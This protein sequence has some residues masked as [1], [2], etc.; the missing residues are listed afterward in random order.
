MCS[1]PNT[2]VGFSVCIL[3]AALRLLC[4]QISYRRRQLFQGSRPI[5]GKFG[6]SVLKTVC[7]KVS[8]KMVKPQL[9]C[10]RRTRTLKSNFSALSFIAF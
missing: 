3:S 8:G 9:F 7:E 2:T 5:K 10:A 6:K 1:G 4:L